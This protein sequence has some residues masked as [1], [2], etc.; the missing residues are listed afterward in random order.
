[1]KLYTFEYYHPPTATWRVWFSPS[2]ESVIIDRGEY[3]KYADNEEWVKPWKKI[4]VDVTPESLCELLN[5]IIE[6]M[7]EE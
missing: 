3:L 1:M 7:D 4:K 2:K 5:S 6:A